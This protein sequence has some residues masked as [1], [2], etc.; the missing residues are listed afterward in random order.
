MVRVG[1][2]IS[3]FLAMFA[4]SGRADDLAPLDPAPRVIHGVVEERAFPETFPG[5]GAL[6]RAIKSDLALVISRQ[7]PVKA[8]GSRGTCSIFSSTGI[9]ESLL[10]IADGRDRDLSESFLEF[11]VMS[12]MKPEAKEG[13]SLAINVPA[14]RSWGAI[15]EETWPYE[16]HDW[17]SGT[18]P[19]E[20]AKRAEETCGKLEGNAK[21]ACL[22]SHRSPD[23][24]SLFPE[25]QQFWQENRLY[26]LGHRV[27][28]RQSEIFQALDRGFPVVVEVEFFYAAWNHRLMTEYGLGE[29]DMEKWERGIVGTPTAEDVRI[30]R[31]HPAGHSVIVVGYDARERVYYFKNSWGTGGFGA[32]SDLVEDGTPG[33]GSIT[34]DYAHRFGSFFGTSLGR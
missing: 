23:D 18:L 17:T 12:K 22:L 10:K 5:L 8:Q 21:Q 19:E 15:P 31:E 9:L 28:R 33:Y 14:M 4:I 27:L 32:E 7:T 3:L 13:S 29:R 11:I 25:A 16:P 24:D 6:N 30:S 2:V 34:F 26:A 1:A 20:E